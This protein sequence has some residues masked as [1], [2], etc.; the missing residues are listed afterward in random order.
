MAILPVRVI[1]VLVIDV[2]LTGVLFRLIAVPFRNFAISCL[3]TLEFCCIP[4]PLE[5]KSHCV[6]IML[7]CK[8]LTHAILISSSLYRV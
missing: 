4:T 3:N 1:F 2:R 5:W 6:G 8:V 7:F